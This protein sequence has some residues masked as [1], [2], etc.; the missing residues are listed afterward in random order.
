M[1][2]NSPMKTMDIIVKDSETGK[3]V[4][5]IG[6]ANTSKLLVDVETFLVGAFGGSVYPFTNDPSKPIS[7][8]AVKLPAGDYILETIAHDEEG[9]S[10]VINNPLIVDNTVPEVN[11]NIKP[12]VIE[13]NDSMYTVE[14][15][16]RAVWL[17]GTAKD[18]T[19]DL[20][21]SKGLDSINRQTKWLTMQTLIP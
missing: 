13:I 12:G 11:M 4:G 5:F 20:L 6:T 19:V 18:A 1:K 16:Q 17:H 9:Q 8:Y 14:D 3:A 7:D 2:L 15:G 21:Q 10:Y